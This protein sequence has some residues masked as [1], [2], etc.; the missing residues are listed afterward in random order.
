MDCADGDFKDSVL[1]YAGGDLSQ[2]L[3]SEQGR[4]FT[5]QHIFGLVHASLSLSE[6]DPRPQNYTP[7]HP[8]IQNI[9]MTKKGIC[10][11]GD[12]GVLKYSRRPSHR[13]A[14][15]S[16]HLFKRE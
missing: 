12:F 13:H 9:F 4:C 1:L 7:R 11:I 6:T 5:E 2:K 14:Q 10:Q 3:K 16:R 8:R 15:S